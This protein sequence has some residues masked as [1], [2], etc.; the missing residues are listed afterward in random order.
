MEGVAVTAEQAGPRKAAE[1]RTKLA[2]IITPAPDG[3][4]S[5]DELAFA[6]ASEPIGANFDAGLAPVA[7][8]DPVVR[9]AGI[10]NGA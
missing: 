4:E 8:D 2:P 7:L 6:L 1:P 5:V 3:S 10:R 9:T